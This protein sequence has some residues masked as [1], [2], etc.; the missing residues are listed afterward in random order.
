[1]MTTVRKSLL[2]QHEALESL[3]NDLRNAAEGADRATVARVSEALDRQLRAH[4]DAE[5]AHLFPPLETPL[6]RE[7]AQARSDHERLRRM[8]ADLVVDADIHAVRAPQIDAFLAALE[9]HAG[10]EDATLYPA[11]E[12]ALSAPAKKALTSR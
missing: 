9:A 3:T 12:D 11:A 5:E 8:L 6:P 7:V 1:M 10:W 4:F 2:D